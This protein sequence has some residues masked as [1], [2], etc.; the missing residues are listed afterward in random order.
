MSLIFITF[1][2]CM[3]SYI[4]SDMVSVLGFQERYVEKD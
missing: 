1:Y 4:K 2:S 3:Q